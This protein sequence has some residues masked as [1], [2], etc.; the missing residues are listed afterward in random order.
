MLNEVINY[1]ISYKFL[2]L[3]NVLGIKQGNVFS[4]FIEQQ[5]RF[6]LGQT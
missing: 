3:E 6:L 5:L 2:C 4:G 1:A